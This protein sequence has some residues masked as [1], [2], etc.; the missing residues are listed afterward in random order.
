MSIAVSPPIFDVVEYIKKLRNAGVSQE[1]AEIQGQEIEHVIN[2]VLHQ[3]KQE[4]REI[5]DSKDLATK[6]DIEVVRKEIEVVR[7]EISQASNK[8][9]IWIVSILGGYGVFFLGIL[10]KGFHWL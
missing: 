6:L 5:F 2:N 1:V 9:I 8:S 3:A 4:S 10:A 7:K